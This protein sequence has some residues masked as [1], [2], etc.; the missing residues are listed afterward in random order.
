MSFKKLE[1]KL[2]GEFTVNDAVIPLRKLDADITS[3]RC[4]WRAFYLNEITLN[5][6]AERLEG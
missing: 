4:G 3:G 2:V 6:K 1:G 5:P